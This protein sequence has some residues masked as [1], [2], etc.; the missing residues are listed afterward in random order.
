MMMSRGFRNSGHGTI[1][2]IFLDT[3]D[4]RI[5]VMTSHSLIITLRIPTYPS[6]FYSD[7]CCGLVRIVHI[8]VTFL[9]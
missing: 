2:R 8:P 1:R 9:P 5:Y 6:R 4:V 3:Y 7:G